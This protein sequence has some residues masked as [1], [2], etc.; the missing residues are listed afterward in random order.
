MNKNKI[1]HRIN[2]GIRSPQIRIVGDD[3]E[4]KICSVQEA[5][6]IADDNYFQSWL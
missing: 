3:I 4:S 5:M 1:F 2:D 6:K